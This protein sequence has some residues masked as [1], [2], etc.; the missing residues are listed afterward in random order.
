M[1]SWYRV[2]HTLTDSISCLKVY[3]A[4]EKSE[5]NLGEGLKEQPNEPRKP[6]PIAMDASVFRGPP[7]TAEEMEKEATW[8]RTLFD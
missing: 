6:K 5:E 7:R 4:L 2:Y 1:G 3:P 8:L